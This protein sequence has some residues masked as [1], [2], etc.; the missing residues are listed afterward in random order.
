MQ[1][2]RIALAVDRLNRP[3][4]IGSFRWSSVGT[5][6]S[7]FPVEA[8]TL[9]PSGHL[10]AFG[11]DHVLVGLCVDGMGRIQVGEG[12][13][14]RTVVSSTGRFSLLARGFEQKPLAWSG[15]REML[16]VAMRPEL[17]DRFVGNER[18]PASLNIDPQYAV[19]DAQV[20]ALV[21]N[22]QAEIRA[23]CP[24][25]KLYGEALSQ[26]LAAYLFGRYSPAVTP[27]VR[28]AGTLSP[29]Q[30]RRVRA[31]VEAHLAHDVGLT[32]LAGLVQLSPHYF[33]MQ[34]KRALGVS[35]HRYVLRERIRKAQRLLAAGRMPI[36]EVAQNLGF[37]DQSHLSLAFRKMTGTTPGRYKRRHG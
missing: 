27:A 11:L 36:S 2:E 32:E 25:G 12:A 19:A 20:V 9:G 4:D 31:Y 6:W 5:R 15:M 16:F 24:C 26:A 10:Q 3:I 23:G 7:G 33:S 29:L 37:S 1:R 21:Q 17:L 30:V 28:A 8:H 14:A 22:M 35:P 18:D 34:F 13:K